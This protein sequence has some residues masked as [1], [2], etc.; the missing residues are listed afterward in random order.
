MGLR[1]RSL[2]PLRPRYRAGDGDRRRRRRGDLDLDRDRDRSRG[3]ARARRDLEPPRSPYR[4][5]LPET[6]RSETG[7][8]WLAGC[9][10]GGGW[11][12][13][14]RSGGVAAAA[15]GGQMRWGRR[16]RCSR[17]ISSGKLL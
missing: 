4:P 17:N 8:A 5:D 2:R 6:G 13:E 1:L 11:T 16:L 3:I 14:A 10:S 12:Q 15:R 9:K 7:G